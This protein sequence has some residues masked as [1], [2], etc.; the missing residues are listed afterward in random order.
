MFRILIGQISHETN[1]FSPFKTG[2]EEFKKKVLVKEDA[3]LETYKGTKSPVWAFVETLRKE[4]D[5][6]IIPSIAAYAMPS[7]IVT[8]EALSQF[9]DFLLCAI[10]RFNPDAILLDLHGA[11]ISE[12]QED[13]DGYILEEVRRAVGESVP[14]AATLDLHAFLTEKMV[15]NANILVPHNKYPHSDMYDRGV[16]AAEL[17]LRTLRN[18]IHPVLKWTP[19]PLLVTFRETEGEEY[20]PVREAIAALEE[21]PGILMASV[22]HSFYLG[23]TRENRMAALAIA[24]GDVQAAQA[25]ANQLASTVWKHREKICRFDTY[26][27]KQA[28]ETMKARGI[29]PVAFADI[30]DN[31]GHGSTCD[32]TKLL[33]ELLELKAERVA[34]AVIADPETVAQCHAAGV[35]ETVDICLGGKLAPA[36]LGDP[37]RCRA[38]IKSL[39]DGIY[40]NGGPMH[41]GVTVDLRKSAVLKIEGITVIVSSMPTQAHNIEVFKN[42]GLIMEDYDVLVLKSAIH[43]R[44]SFYRV[45][46]DTYSVECPGLYSADLFTIPYKATSDQ[47]YPLKIDAVFDCREI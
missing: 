24:D 42:H 46:K 43:Y 11:M 31:P 3:I 44:S 6:D 8:A 47:I 36:F 14:I 38:Y 37:I 10:N 15:K 18:E 40:V 29:R 2:V 30:C 21:Q 33:R 17:L 22:T 19:M 1:T 20:R 34:C 39:H 16:V 23:D 4:P 28:Y 25:A 27:T 26:T 45:Y 32:G 35:G 9:L 12:L 41:G 13:G 5:V 7:G